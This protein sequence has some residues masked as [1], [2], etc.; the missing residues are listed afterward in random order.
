MVFFDGL[1]VE[2]QMVYSEWFHRLGRK[3]V[4]ESTTG[5]LKGSASPDIGI[6]HRVVSFLKPWFSSNDFVDQSLLWAEK[7]AHVMP[8]NRI[9]A[10]HSITALLNCAIKNVLCYN[11]CH[12]D[13]PLSDALTEIY[14]TKKLTLSVLFGISSCMESVHKELAEA[15]IKN[16]RVTDYPAGNLY[17][18]DVALETGKWIPLASQQ[19][20]SILDF[21]Q[22]M[23]FDTIIQ[24]ADTVRHESLMKSLL[25]ESRPLILCGPPGCGKSMVVLSAL[26]KEADV[27][28]STVNFSSSTNPETLIR[29]LEHLCDY[30][31]TPH[32][33]TLSP[34]FAGKLVLFCD[35]INLP[36]EDE[37]GTQRV[38]SLMRQLLEHHGFW[39]FSR[40][41][42]VQLNRV[43]FVGAWWGVH[44][45]L[46][47]HARSLNSWQQSTN[48]P[49]KKVSFASIL[50]AL[51]G[52]L[53]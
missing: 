10:I 31:K 37:Y 47:R 51:H 18:W 9:A 3:S 36:A 52:C 33:L 11:D 7:Q 45:L 50:K 5:E 24:T 20:S 4:R 26:R 1:T 53:Y 22:L 25:S 41:S 16:F 12:I 29:S 46:I 38:M 34:K 27:Q 21:Q 28:I 15:F 32:G 30:R 19:H 17:E 35:E 48:G 2:P 6:Q 14:V 13:F 8:F 42:W 44:L 23:R 43:Y 40:K 49:W 39:S